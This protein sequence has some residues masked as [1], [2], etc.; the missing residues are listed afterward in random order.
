MGGAIKVQSQNLQ[1]LVLGRC[2]GDK[3]YI[4]NLNPEPKFGL[5][6][7]TYFRTITAF[8]YPLVL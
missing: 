7:S 6:L 1:F 5:N 2:S 8:Q 3:N 4:N